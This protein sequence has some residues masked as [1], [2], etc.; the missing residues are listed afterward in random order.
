MDHKAFANLSTLKTLNLTGNK[1]T[2]IPTGAFYNLP[3]LTNVYLSHNKLRQVAES[4]FT[5]YHDGVTLDLSFNKFTNVSKDIFDIRCGYSSLLLAYNK[6][7]SLP[8]DLFSNILLTRTLDLSSNQLTELTPSLFNSS[9]GIH[10]LST[11]FLQRNNLTSLPED[12]FVGLPNLTYLCL[13]HNKFVDLADAAFSNTRVQYIYLFGNN[14]QNLSN[15]SFENEHIMEVHLYGNPVKIVNETAFLGVNQEANLFLNCDTVKEIEQTNIG[16]KCVSPTYVPEIQVKKEFR[17]SFQ[18]EG[19][20]CS[21]DDKGDQARCEPCPRGTYGN[22]VDKCIPCPPG[23]YYQDGIGMKAEYPKKMNCKECAN[24]TYVRNGNATSIGQ[25]EV[26]P[27]GTNKTRHAGF[28]ACFCMEGYARLDRFGPC[29]ICLEEVEEGVNCTTGFDYKALRK[30]FY[31]NWTFA[32]ANLTNYQRFVDNLKNETQFFS[33]LSSDVKYDQEM[34]KV[35]KCP[36]M[37]SCP[38]SNSST[39]DAS[40]AKG[41][42]GWLCTKCLPKFYSV[43]NSCIE[44]PGWEILLLEIAGISCLFVLAFTGIFWQYKKEQLRLDNKRSIVDILISRG[45]IVLGFYQVIGEFFTSMHEVNW[46]GKLYVIGE[47]INYLELNILRIFVRPQCFNENFHM[48]PKIEFIVG[49]VF[50]TVVIL[51]SALFY[52]LR[53]AYFMYRQ[54]RQLDYDRRMSF[55]ERLKSKVLTFIIVLL[56]VTYPP[57]CTIIFQ[58]YPRACE[59]FCYDIKETTCMTVLR[60]DYHIYCDKK[61]TPYQYSAYFATAVYVFGFPAVLLYLLWKHSPRSKP[62]PP[63]HTMIQETREQS[64]QEDDENGEEEEQELI[65]LLRD[66]PPR[67]SPVP[68][69]LYSLCENYQSRFWYWEIVELTRKVTQTVLITLLGWEDKLTVLLTIGISVL[70]LTLHARY[71]P[72]KSKFEQ[73]LQMFSLTAIL[74]NVLVAAMEVPDEYGDAFATALIMLNVVVILIIAVEALVGLFHFLKIS[75]VHTHMILAVT[76]PFQ[77]VMARVRRNSDEQE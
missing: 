47:F 54:R 29:E 61:L 21:V 49:M 55:Q 76:V 52:F 32:E 31:W 25:C 62:S 77:W 37:D 6:I 64:D 2:E 15:S 7:E 34:P 70:F 39:V 56:F 3:S 41:H 11:L 22:G 69:W 28:R 48:N 24:G 5:G 33:N 4:F 65:P 10:Q 46:A 23:G 59:T 36:R 20:V 9:N 71:M 16:I 50:P 75:R 30:G 1:I 40:C 53:K 60:S 67:P 72:M 74:I 8:Q 17:W 18:S 19:F 66:E 12:A 58:L 38:N 51:M 27:D 73:R 13:F 63:R 57:I 35:H 42:T 44:C 26:C 68:T 14:F 43:M 45:K